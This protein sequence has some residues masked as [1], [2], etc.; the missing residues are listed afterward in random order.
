M[1]AACM[2]RETPAQLALLASSLLWGLVDRHFTFAVLELGIVREGL[3][4]AL[5][6]L[7]LGP[8]LQ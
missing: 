8:G 2:R 3:L 6:G 4:R 5:A 1:L 7:P